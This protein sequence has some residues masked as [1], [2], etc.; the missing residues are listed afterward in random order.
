MKYFLVKHKGAIDRFWRM[1]FIPLVFRNRTKSNLKQPL[2]S[3]NVDFVVSLRKE[4]GQLY[5]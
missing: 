5:F 4:F 3:K 2:T 1:L